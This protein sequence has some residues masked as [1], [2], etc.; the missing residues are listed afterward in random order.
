M[1]FAPRFVKQM[2][3]MM[4]VINHKKLGNIYV[5]ESRH[6]PISA[7]ASFNNSRSTDR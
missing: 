6:Y 5:E 1:I 2:T 7:P 3:S 4:L